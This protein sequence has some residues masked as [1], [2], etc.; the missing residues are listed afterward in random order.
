MKLIHRFTFAVAFLAFLSGPIAAQHDNF[1]IELQ[2]L[3]DNQIPI[4]SFP[5]GDSVPG[6]ADDIGTAFAFL[7][8]NNGSTINYVLCYPLASSS[9]TGELES[10]SETP[11]SGEVFVYCPGTI[12]LTAFSQ[13]LIFFQAVQPDI[14][15]VFSIKSQTVDLQLT[16]QQAVNENY[17]E[18]CFFDS[19]G[20]GC[21][22][23]AC[24]DSLN[25]LASFNQPIV[26]LSG[27]CGNGANF[28]LPGVQYQMNGPNTAEF[29]FATNFDFDDPN[30]RQIFEH[31]SFFVGSSD[32]PDAQPFFSFQQFEIPLF[33]PGD[34]N[35]DGNVDL[36]D[37]AGFLDCLTDGVFIFQC[38]IN[39]DQNI[40]L[41]DVAPFIE[42]LS[43]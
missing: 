31:F 29:E 17:A 22:K 5:I 9:I 12:D 15:S 37:V 34:T 10:G 32:V 3:I 28:R 24:A 20:F 39:G 27:C 7:D 40:N 30:F 41:L 6:F 43:N 16:T 35:L 26:C 38:D 14:T 19:A 36:L 4:G 25:N 1:P 13:F 2:Q 8:V 42:L 18:Y 23:P 11:M 21:N 33:Q